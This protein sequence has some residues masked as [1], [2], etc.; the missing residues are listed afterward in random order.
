L[1]IA[2][3]VTPSSVASLARLLAWLDGHDWADLSLIDRSDLLI[4]AAAIV[5]AVAHDEPLPIRHGL[6]LSLGAPIVVAAA[7]ATQH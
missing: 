4:D 7:S 3:T 6:R 2:I 5:E 1:N